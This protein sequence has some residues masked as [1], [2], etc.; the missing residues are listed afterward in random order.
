MIDP[1]ELAEAVLANIPDRVEYALATEVIRLSESL[2][3]ATNLI[4]EL[5]IHISGPSLERCVS[6]DQEA[7]EFLNSHIEV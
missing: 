3:V 5:Y 4:R 6:C 1:L 2:S 7:T